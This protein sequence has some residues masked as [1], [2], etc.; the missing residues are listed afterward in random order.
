MSD[1]D[2]RRDGQPSTDDSDGLDDE[3]LRPEGGDIS[4][5]TITDPEDLPASGQGESDGP[6][7]DI[8][9]RARRSHEGSSGDDE[10][11]DAFEE[12]EVDDVDVGDLWEELEGEG[13]DDTVDDPRSS[14]ERDVRVVAKRDYCQRCQHFTAPP[15]M[16]CTSDSGEILE[17]V[18]TEQFKVADCPI[19]RGEEELENL[20]R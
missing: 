5:D 9:E 14:S 16:R 18:D 17:L 1:D 2:E 13:L 19:L 15:E 4:D 7:G 20:R 8:A 6:L 12:V 3:F 11:M 10:V